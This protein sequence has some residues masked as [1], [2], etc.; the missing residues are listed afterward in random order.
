MQY[1]GNGNVLQ[2]VK[3]NKKNDDTDTVVSAAHTELASAMHNDRIN[4]FAASQGHGFAA[5]QANDLIDTLKGK[6]ASI[7]GDDNAK[8]GP[9]RMVDG[10]WI[11]SKYC[12][13]ARASIDAA[14]K[15]GQYR[16]IDNN[17]HP[18]QIEVPSDQYA[19]AVEIM[20][21]RIADGKVPGTTN[22]KDAETIV[23][24]GNID[25]QTA[26]NIAKAG[27]I[28]SLLFDA[29]HG[30]VIA[31]NAFGISAAIVFAKAL[32]DG[33]NLNKAIDTA[34]YAGLQAGG[35]AFATS[36]ITAQLTRTGLNN[37]LMGP[38]IEIVKALPSSVRKELVK[39]LREGPLVYG[40]AA[41]SNLA[42]LVRSNLLANAVVLMTLS[43]GDITNF[44]RGRISAKQLF[45]DV[46]TIGGGLS[47]S[48]AGGVIGGAIGAMTP[49]PGG[50]KIGEFAGAIAG[51]AIAGNGTHAVLN[52]FVEDDVVA[53]LQIIN[54]RLIVLAQQYLLSEEELEIVVGDLR[55]ILI[56]E[57]LLQMYA[58]DD[59]EAFA[60]AMISDCIKK[61]IRWRAH[62]RLPSNETF[63]A[64]LGRVIALSADDKQLQAHLAK[65]N[66]D[67]VAIGKQLLGQE[68][69]KEAA[70]KAWYVTKQMNMISAQQEGC[71][72]QMKQ[73]EM[74]YIQNNR[75]WQDRLKHCR[76][77]FNQWIKE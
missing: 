64:G 7:L 69:S 16:Y 11:Q 59:K 20:R 40:N 13:S 67:T 45:K 62:V 56:K 23:R 10:A 73:D 74:Q 70:N 14:F 24:K 38:S 4:R 34:M 35:V 58:S 25:Y 75:Q 6:N 26:C 60:D 18:M 43:A 52:H 22:L 68:V 37:A 17:G 30:T 51:G 55:Q 77:E 76:R 32:W 8:N 44:F 57:K 61:T 63:T 48:L 50:M 5:E 66:V 47:G 53:L 46:M 49:I 65:Q 31:T 54:D 33:E 19:E 41:S 71:L 42:K 28:D 27:T 3:Y 29:V 15:N 21:K 36:V 72:T 39:V 9:D 1:T 2:H 12:N